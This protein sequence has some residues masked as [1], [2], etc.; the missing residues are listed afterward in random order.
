MEYARG[1]KDLEVDPKAPR[2]RPIE[3]LVSEVPGSLLA[4]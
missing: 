1:A 4:F 3:K 2:D